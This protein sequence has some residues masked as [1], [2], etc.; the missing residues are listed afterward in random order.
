MDQHAP[1]PAAGHDPGLPQMA[2]MEGERRRRQPQLARDAPDRQPLRPGRHQEPED[3]EP[4]LLREG[5]KRGEGVGLF[6]ASRMI[7][8][9]PRRKPKAIPLF[10]PPPLA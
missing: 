5:R 8:T 6:H 3:V 9:N 7:E 10:N 2:E 1:L 4:G